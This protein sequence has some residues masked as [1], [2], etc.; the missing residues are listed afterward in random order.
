MDAFFASC[1][2]AINPSYRNKP[3]I[4]GGTE[5]D[6]RSI[7]SCPNY[8]ARKRGVKTAMPLSQALKLIPDGIFIRGTRGLYSDYS[9]KVFNILNKYSPLVQPVSIDEAYMDV[10]GVLY[11]YDNDYYKLAVLIKDEIKYDLKITCSIGISSKK[12][13]SKIASDMNKPDGI[14]IVPFGREKEFLSKLPVEK[15]PGVGKNTE[16]RL[17]HFG[18]NI[19]GD[20]LKFDRSFYESGFGINSSYLINI[21]SGKDEREV[22]IEESERKSLSKETTFE[23][24]MIDRKFLE[25]E[26]YILLE[27]ACLKLRKK[28]LK[29]KTITI[30]IKY[31]DFIVN[32][33]SKTRTIYSNLETNFFEDSV[34]LLNSLTGKNKSIRLLG[35]KLSELIQDD[36][37]FQENIFNDE[38]KMRNITDKL[39]K[40]RSKYNFDIIKFGKTFDPSSGKNG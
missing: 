14:T 40:I 4:V 36:S 9:K 6:K 3:L 29:A 1:E 21:A 16:I 24:D 34:S 2:E 35:V 10:T 37:I 30:K 27:K 11:Q 33:K 32:Q 12:I 5:N 17:K 23:K 28:C 18:I 13:C 25:K 22:H 26:L 39:D 15:I 7:V 20:I 31:S 19:I 38:N 8:I